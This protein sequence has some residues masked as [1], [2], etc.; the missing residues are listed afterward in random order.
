MEVKEVEKEEFGVEFEVKEVEGEEFSVEVKSLVQELLPEHNLSD[1]ALA[2][3]YARTQFALKTGAPMN[4]TWPEK[5]MHVGFEDPG[6]VEESASFV[7]EEDEDIVH[8]KSSDLSVT[9]GAQ[10]AATSIKSE[11][12]IFNFDQLQQTLEK[13][14]LNT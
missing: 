4:F 1:A 10:S 3:A 9:A 2:R 13:F 6:F 11:S 7:A 8:A 14:R 12:Q 5:R